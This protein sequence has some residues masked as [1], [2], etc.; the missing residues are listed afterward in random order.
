MK[1]TE[2]NGKTVTDEQSSKSTQV[3]T[4]VKIP[5]TKEIV[6]TLCSDEFEGRLIGSKGNDKAGEYVNKIFKDIGLA[7]LFGN[8]YYEKYSQDIIKVYG[9]GEDSKMGTINNVVGV[10]KG[11]NSK[12]AVV[13]SAHFDHIGYQD[14]KIIRG[15]L[16]NASGMSALIKVA[17]N[18]KEKS[19][20]KP[21]DM[22]IVIC[23]F[24]G[25]EEGLAGSRAFVDEIIS[26]SL[27]ENLYNI[28]IDSIGS[29]NGGKLALK[30]KSK[31][32][33]KLYASVKTTL[34]KNNIEFADT[35]IRGAS[36]HMSF[37]NEKIPNF[38]F[39][40]EN[41]KELIHKPTD[42]PDTL[43]YEQIDRIANAISDFVETN[44]GIMFGAK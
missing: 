8:S 38:F 27:Y 26:K 9:G 12:K 23:A 41:I 36:D 39:V 25:E 32:S 2:S 35:T 15:A 37:E 3:E 31:V 43:D 22:D 30:N 11:K 16:D 44:N 10:I 42:T 7:P 20:E 34:K 24:N 18:L 13:I 21:F 1:S 6:N 40:Q 33:N 5:T 19:K 29:K 14:G 28:N 17:N 4:H